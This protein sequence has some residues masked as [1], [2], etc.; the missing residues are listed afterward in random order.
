MTDHKVATRA[1]WL[2]ARLELPEAEKEPTHRSDDLVRRRQEVP[3][4][5]IEKAPHPARALTL[6]GTQSRHGLRR[7][8]T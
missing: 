4:V 8:Q 7:D 2:A 6:G 1:E 3:L 5:R